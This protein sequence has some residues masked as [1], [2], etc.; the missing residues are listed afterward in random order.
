[1]INKNKLPQNK[2]Q[3]QNHTADGFSE[4][5]GQGG[6]GGGWSLNWKSG[7]MGGYN[8]WNPE[9][10]VTKWR[11]YIFYLQ[12]YSSALVAYVAGVERG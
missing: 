10:I 12:P 8:H 11:H 3:Q 2:K 4:I 7:G 9:G 1:M 6:E 5:W